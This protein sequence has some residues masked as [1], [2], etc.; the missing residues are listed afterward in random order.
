MRTVY[1]LAAAGDGL[2]SFF[3]V[4][5]APPGEWFRLLPADL[6]VLTEL[7]EPESDSPAAW[8]TLGVV[9]FFFSASFMRRRALSPSVSVL[10][11]FSFAPLIL[12]GGVGV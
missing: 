3:L 7:V 8:L 4:A 5:V 11:F 10:G 9:F 12:L 2:S 1:Y 6:V